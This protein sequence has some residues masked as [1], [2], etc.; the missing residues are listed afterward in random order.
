MTGRLRVVLDTNVV[1]SALL[2]QD[3]P[4]ELLDKAGEGFIELFTSET[5]LSELAA[6]LEQPK[7]AGRVQT[8]GT[9]SALLVQR[10]RYAA[11]V[12]SPEPLG[13]PVS[14]D[15]DDDHVLACALCARADVVVSGD[16]D[17][18]VL[19]RVRATRILTVAAALAGLS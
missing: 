2:W 11:T 1:I 12:V 19:G 18:L 3:K 6:V 10:F 15:P 8:I 16:E 13:A 4:G 7:L 5:L 14:R 9:T 17:L